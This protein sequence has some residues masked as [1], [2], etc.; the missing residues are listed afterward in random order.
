M[1]TILTCY[2]I[3]NNSF[4]CYNTC[5]YSLLNEVHFFSKFLFYLSFVMF[6]NLI[7]ITICYYKINKTTLKRYKD[8]YNINKKNYY[9]WL[10]NIF[11]FRINHQKY[12]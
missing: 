4:S 12:I 2:D 9:L 3:Y 10:L 6:L 7:L 8:F 1:S 11:K 5:V